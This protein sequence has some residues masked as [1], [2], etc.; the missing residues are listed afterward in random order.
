MC[1]SSLGTLVNLSVRA[2]PLAALVFAAGCAS[3]AEDRVVGIYSLDPVRSNIPEFSNFPPLQNRMRALSRNTRLKIRSDHSF[4]LT[5][6]R[7][8]EGTWQLE[9]DTIHLRP[10]DPEA[11]SILAKEDGEFLVTLDEDGEGLVVE[12]PTPV[13]Q[14]RLYLRKTG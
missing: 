2:L 8:T 4:I 14:I 5:G 7:V 13:G 10:K 3:S 9:G 12:Q 11:A 6:I 1:E